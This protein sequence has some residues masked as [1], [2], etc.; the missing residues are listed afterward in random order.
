[1]TI[2]TTV[3]SLNKNKLETLSTPLA[4][5]SFVIGTLLLITYR[6]FPEASDVIV[7]TGIIYVLLALISNSLLF[8]YLFYHFVIHKSQREHLVVKM[9]IMLSNIPIA[10]L[11]LYLI[12]INFNL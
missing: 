9:L 12:I 2:T 11:Y 5:I 10:I 8:F 4:I 1:M 3:T 7:M 6:M